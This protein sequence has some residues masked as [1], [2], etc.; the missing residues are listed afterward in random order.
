VYAPRVDSEVL[1]TAIA[2]CLLSGLAWA[3][4]Y[5]LLGRLDPNSFG[6]ISARSPAIANHDLTKATLLLWLF[7]LRGLVR[8]LCRQACIVRQVKLIH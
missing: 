5:A 6:F 2:G 7:S 4:A 3:L 1:C 8:L